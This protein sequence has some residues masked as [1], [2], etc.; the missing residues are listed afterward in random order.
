[1]QQALHIEGMH[2]EACV[3]RVNKAL[4]ALAQHVHVTLD[5]PQ[6]LLQVAAPL[7]LQTV[8]SALQ[9]AGDYRAKPAAQLPE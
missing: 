2:C 3:N 4:A 9:K 7:P 6:A 5:P 8:Q 1:M